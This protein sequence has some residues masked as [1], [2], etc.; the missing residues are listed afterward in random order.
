M[1]ITKERKKA[2]VAQYQDLAKRATGMIL[3]SYSGLTVKE[4]EGLR[5][6]IREVGGEFHIVKNSLLEL[7]F[8]E[9]DLPLPDGAMEGTTAIGFATEEV[10]P[11]AKAIVDLS[12]DGEVISLKGGIVDGKLVDQGRIVMLADLPPMPVVQSQLLSVMS[13]PAS[14]I[15]GVLA[16]ALRQMIGVMN[17]YAQTESAEAA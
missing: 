4:L 1:A 16:G 14:Q 10:P 11:I 6:Q 8:K 17:A 5:N 13:S 3:T 9:L 7:A 15:A 2:L 12:R